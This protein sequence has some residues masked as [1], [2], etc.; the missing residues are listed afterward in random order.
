MNTDKRRTW[1]L[2]CPECGEAARRCPPR[3]WVAATGPRPRWS[4][5]DGEALCPVVGLTGYQPA[6]PRPAPPA[7]RVRRRTPT[8][9]RTPT[10]G[11]PN[12]GAVRLVARG[13]AV[14]VSDD[15][16]SVAVVS[17]LQTEALRELAQPV[18]VGGEAAD[19]EVAVYVYALHAPLA[20]PGCTVP[21]GSY[22][23]TV[24]GKWEC[25]YPVPDA[26]V[27]VAYAE[28]IE[29]RYTAWAEPGA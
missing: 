21:A 15:P 18:A 4:H 11:V 25:A 8:P 12:A 26:A 28:Q 24:R 2:V 10:A 7:R 29:Q 16:A 1:H 5:L 23:R 22:V 9:G 27:A 14:P 17:D 6:D 3:R 13:D 20:Y 19:W